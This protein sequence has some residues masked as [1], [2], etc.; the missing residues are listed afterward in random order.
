MTVGCCSSRPHNVKLMKFRKPV[1]VIRF[2]VSDGNIKPDYIELYNMHVT[3]VDTQLL[4]QTERISTPLL[5]T[6]KAAPKSDSF[7]H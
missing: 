7:A 5:L 6:A 3:Q 2:T 4:R 1:G